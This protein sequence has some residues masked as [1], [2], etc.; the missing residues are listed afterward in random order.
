MGATV[1]SNHLEVLGEVPKLDFSGFSWAI[2]EL[3]L[4]VLE[5][6]LNAVGLRDH[7]RDVVESLESRWT[8][9]HV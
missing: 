5:N 2:Y 4:L 6:L 1:D 7:Y 9:S 8:C 3:I